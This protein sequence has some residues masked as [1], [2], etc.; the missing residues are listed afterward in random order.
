MGIH[1]LFGHQPFSN[2]IRDSAHA[3]CDEGKPTCQRCAKSKRECRGYRHEF[4]VVHRDQTNSTLRRV[5]RQETPNSNH[6]YHSH[7]QPRQQRHQ[8][9]H[10]DCQSWQQ[11]TSAS[12][13]TPENALTVPLAQ[14]AS[15][16]FASNFIL[17]PLSATP[18]GFLDYLVPL[19]KSEPHG[20]SLLHAFNAC[21]FALLSNRTKADTI[22]LSQLSLK[23]HTLALAQTHK[24]LSDPATAAADA[25]L[26][27]V[28]LLSLYETITA[29]KE[30]RMLA[31]RSHIDGAVNIVKTRGRE[32]CKTKTG[33]LLFGAVRH[34]IV[35]PFPLPL[36]FFSFFF[37]L[38]QG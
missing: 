4:D 23:E 19:V 26:A 38:S 25:T 36:F 5:A 8:R 6:H 34:Q 17:V 12:Q 13:P 35:S 28:L 29:R 14:R 3:Q 11:Q 33:A 16:Y 18:H 21:A 7:Q 9:Y 32:M 37:L 24:A 31:W 20:S 1:L 22:N 15:C 2:R 10:H 30:S 27:T